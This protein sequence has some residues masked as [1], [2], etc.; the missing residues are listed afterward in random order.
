MRQ[1]IENIVYYS[2]IILEVKRIHLFLNTV[3]MDELNLF[4]TNLNISVFLLITRRVCLREEICNL[5]SCR[6]DSVHF[7][8]CRQTTA[9]L[10]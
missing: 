10:I 6:F 4:G 5:I 1:R 3:S 7:D 8:T 2:R 9:R